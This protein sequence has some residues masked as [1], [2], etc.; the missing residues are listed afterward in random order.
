MLDFNRI[1]S[2]QFLDE[3]ERTRRTL[4]GFHPFL[5][6]ITDKEINGER[7]GNLFGDSRSDKGVA[8]VTTANVEGSIIPSGKLAVYFLY[9]LARYTLNF[10]VPT[11]KNHDDTRACVYD[12]KKLKTDLLK[13]MNSHPFCDQCRRELLIE[14]T[15]MSSQQYLALVSIFAQSGRL[16][17]EITVERITLP[18]VFIG[19]SVEGLPVANKI[20]SL[21]QYEFTCEV[22]NQG[23]VFGLGEV[24]IDAL[25]V[26]TSQYDFGIF[27]F[28]P[29]DEIHMRGENKPVARDN[30]IFELGLFIGKLSRRRAFLVHPSGNAITLP[31]DL[32]GMATAKYNPNSPNLAATLGP[33]C[34]SIR[35]AI[36]KA[37]ADT[38]H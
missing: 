1:Q 20:Q 24:T 12:R 19:A 16:L 37:Q 18:R 5:I 32:A 35:E 9:Y 36:A 31:S 6:S 38:S 28:T 8:I 26:A 22:W 7:F 21:L 33:V 11:R 30:V 10:I 29:D 17:E 3:M 4:R 15:L 27:V 14:A 34:Q 23:T 13:S 25:E 2:T